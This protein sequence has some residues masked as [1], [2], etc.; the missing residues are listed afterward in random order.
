V[1]V[2]EQAPELTAS[3]VASRP[4][5]LVFVT[6]TSGPSRRVEGFVAQVLQRRANHDTF[7]LRYL[8]LEA[9]PELARRLGIVQVPTVLVVEGGRVRI[10]VEQ[11]RGAAEI[12]SALGPW[13]R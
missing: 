1:S 6:A 7:E 8:D 2:E 13:L 4:K 9:N 10:R 12:R 11:P 3:L 5:L